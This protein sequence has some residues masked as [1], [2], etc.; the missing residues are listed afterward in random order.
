MR[1]VRILLTVFVFLYLMVSGLLLACNHHLWNDEYFS[2][3]YSITGISY[4]KIL[5]GGITE[6]NNSPLFYILQKIQCDLFSYQPPAW[7]GGDVGGAHL[8]DQLFLRVQ[9]VMAGA[10]SLSVLFYYFCRRNSWGIGFY[11]VL[12]AMTSSMFCNHW[13]EARPYALWF[14]LGLFQMLFLMNILEDS[15]NQNK[16]NWICLI[17][18]HWLLALTIMVS[19]VQIVAAGVILWIYNRRKL[20][21]YVPLVLVPLVIC[22]Y[23]HAYAPHFHV[24]FTESPIV[25][26]SANFPVYRM[27]IIFVSA[28]F[29]IFRYR[30]ENWAAKPEIKYLA[31]LSLMLAAFGLIFLKLYLGQL[32]GQHGVQISNRYFMSL[33]PVDIVG[34]VLYSEFLMRAIPSKIW[35][36]AVVVVMLFTGIVVIH[37]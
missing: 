34:T 9:P 10:L 14:A 24:V 33:V 1:L 25:L 5:S 21:L 32:Q 36:A 11:A 6:G 35:A 23:Y 8:F 27:F 12:L 15:N 17:L 20:S 22:G 3:I 31:F 37:S 16:K 28:V 26:I 29:L 4:G 2:M 30:S 13:A 7:V 19:A 18:V